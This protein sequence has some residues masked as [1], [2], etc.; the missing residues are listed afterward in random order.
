MKRLRA[1][2]SLRNRNEILENWA[3]EITNQVDGKISIAKFSILWLRKAVKLRCISRSASFVKGLR[4]SLVI[5]RWHL[6]FFHVHNYSLQ[7]KASHEGTTN[8]FTK[9]Y[10]ESLAW[11]SKTCFFTMNQLTVIL[12]FSLFCLSSSTARCS[13]SRCISPA[14]EIYFSIVADDHAPS[15]DAP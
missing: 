4:K 13:L 15:Y 5:V 7:C 14:Q 3:F 12:V 10:N 11:N 9:N 2:E 8:N 1:K 6:A